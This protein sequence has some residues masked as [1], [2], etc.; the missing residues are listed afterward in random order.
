[1]GVKHIHIAPYDPRWPS[2]FDEEAVHI[3]NALGDNC[4]AV[5][6]VGSTSVPGL[7]AKPKIDIIGVVKNPVKA[8]KQLEEVGFS[9]RGEWNIPFKYGFTKRGEASINLHVFEEGNPE[10]ELNLLFR[11]YL[12]AHSKERD[13]YAALKTDLLSDDSSFVRSNGGFAGYTL[14]KH[15]FIDSIH[16]KTGFDGVRMIH[17]THHVE[18]EA[19]RHFRQHYFF[20]K[21]DIP[22]PFTW[23]F[24]H[25]AHVHLV[26][27]QGADI[28]G[29]AHIQR[30]PEARAA[31]RIIVIDEP[32]RNTGLGIQFLTLCEKW[33]KGQ[34]IH[35]L[36]I[37]S[38]PKA[39][40]FYLKN[41][42][43]EMPFNDPEGYESHPDDTAI[44]KLL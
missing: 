39:L 27:C 44:G 10:I 4:V 6:H 13:E 1:M 21:L 14:G 9:Y 41:S 11:D 15:D 20:D 3:I 2:M 35:T 12:R 22:D 16:R 33:L 24:D 23:T 19:A 43:R 28:V 7:A 36:H 37:E 42:Y 32:F 29:Y 31:M 40:P 30:W 8:I 17:C 38:S 18:W 34:G 25:P 5:H 26:L